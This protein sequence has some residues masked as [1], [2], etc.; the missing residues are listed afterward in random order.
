MMEKTKMKAEEHRKRDQRWKAEK[1]L[2]ERKLLW[3]QEQKIIFCDTSVLDET[4]KAYVIAMRKHIASA[5]E[6][7]VK[8]GVSTNEQG[9]GGDAEEAESL[10]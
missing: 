5:K 9:S 8:G 10:M 2:E 3:E 6:A 1:E 4:Q 7:L